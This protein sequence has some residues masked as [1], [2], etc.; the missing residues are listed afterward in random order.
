MFW[1]EFYKQ[2]A[3]TKLV[4]QAWSKILNKKESIH[5]YL[6]EEKDWFQFQATFALL[7][8]N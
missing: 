5:A 1:K 8:A 3:K 6:V 2:L 4:V 7:Y